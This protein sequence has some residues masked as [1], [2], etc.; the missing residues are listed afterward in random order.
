MF[1]TR[2]EDRRAIA[3]ASIVALAIE[4]RRVVNL[5]EE[6][7]QRPIACFGRIEDDLNRLG[8]VTVIAVGGVRH[9]AAGISHPCGQDAWLS[10]DQILQAPEAATGKSGMVLAHP[11]SST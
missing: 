9:L 10:G 4:R 11:M 1:I 2:V 7:Q 5:E 3:G 8:M 6:F